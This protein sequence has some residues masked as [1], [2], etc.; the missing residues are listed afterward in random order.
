MRDLGPKHTPREIGEI[1]GRKGN[2]LPRF[3]SNHKHVPVGR[4]LIGLAFGGPS[5]RGRQRKGRQ[6]RE[7]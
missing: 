6:Y 4:L 7:E 2:R 3:V 5:G 1:L